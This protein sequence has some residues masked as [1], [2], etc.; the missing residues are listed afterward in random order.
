MLK[1]LNRLVT[2]LKKVAD[3]NDQKDQQ[4]QSQNDQNQKDQQDQGQ[5]DQQDQQDQG[6]ESQQDQGQD[7]QNQQDQQ[8]QQGQP[9]DSQDQLKEIVDVITTLSDQ[10]TNLKYEIDKVKNSIVDQSKFETPD[11]NTTVLASFDFMKKTAFLQI[12]DE[13]N[14]VA[15]AVLPYNPKLSN[16]I[17]NVMDSL[18]LYNK[19]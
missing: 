9:Q 1:G 5:Q 13:L 3:D 6:Q 11:L 19:G 10:I 12:M 2:D 15:D 4:D 14:D 7:D 18:R 8:D 17:D 16:R